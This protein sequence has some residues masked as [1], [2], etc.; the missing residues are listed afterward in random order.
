MGQ[1]EYLPT[2]LSSARVSCSLQYQKGEVTAMVMPMCSVTTH[3]NNYVQQFPS[4]GPKAGFVD[5]CCAIS[6]HPHPMPIRQAVLLSPR[7]R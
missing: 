6:P 1:D 7:Y 4:Q 5:V 3:P 2:S